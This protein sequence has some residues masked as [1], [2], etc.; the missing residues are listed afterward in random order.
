M[1]VDRAPHRA[2]VGTA[3]KEVMESL[4]S[5]YHY[6][7]DAVAQHAATVRATTAAPEIVRIMHHTEEYPGPMW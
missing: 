5:L 2:R 7:G 4:G 3:E 6:E 1:E